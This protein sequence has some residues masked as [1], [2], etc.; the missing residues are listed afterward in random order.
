M[1][2]ISSLAAN[3]SLL[4][5]IFRTRSRLFNLET[6][7][8]SEKISQT[9][10]GIA[11]QSERLINQENTQA[12]LEQYIQ[13]N[14]L[15]DL[16]LKV[17]NKVV[18]NI[19]KVVSEFKTA[20]LD[21]QTSDVKDKTEV[22]DI[23][24][25]AF[26]S[27][28]SIE[29]DLNTSVDGRF[30]FAGARIGTQPVNFGLTNLADYQNIF[31][32]SRIQ[33]PTTRDAHLEDFT[34]NKD[35]GTSAANWLQF[36]RNVGAVAQVDTITVGGTVEVGDKFSV[37]LNGVVF[38]FVAATTSANDVAVGLANAIN[39]GTEPVTAS[40]PAGGVFTLTADTAGTAFTNTVATTETDDTAADAQTIAT[41]S[42]TPNTSGGSIVTGTSSEFTNVTVGSTITITGTGGVNDGTYEVTGKTGTT[43]NIRTEQ[44]TDEAANPVT[45]SYQDPADSTK[46]ITVN[47]TMAFTR[48]NN[49]MVRSAGDVITAIPVGAK[50]TITNSATNNETFTVKSND[51][52]NLVVESK[53]FTD[54]GT[55]GAPYFTYT[56][57][58]A[59]NNLNFVDG[60]ASADTIIGPA[61]TFQDAAGNALPVGSK[62]TVTG[63]ANNG[64]TFTIASVSSDASTVTL[65]STDA[66][67]AAN[68]ETSVLRIEKAAGTISSTS[69]F[70]G[71]EVSMTHRVDETR[72]FE[73]D[74]N[75][76]DPGFEKAIR[77]M[78]II[79][80]GIFQ[81][82]GGLDQNTGRIDNA[83]YL[84]NSALVR[85]PGGTPPF[86]TELTS[87]IEQIELDVGFDRSLI[88][89]TNELHF[90]II[91]FMQTSI[92]NTE[93]INRT[94]VTTLLL[95]QQ[96]ALEASFQAF[97]RIRQLNLGN[98]LPIG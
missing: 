20:L 22:K 65:V 67:T 69:F 72:K 84:L 59:V 71:D 45:I 94:E 32:G 51:G 16:R 42:T 10:G 91:N 26:S 35:S 78:K 36:E 57:A 85:S 34:F 11:A 8:A 7:L 96:L 76:I 43:L 31:D 74:L 68:S 66:V 25:K 3:T 87:N 9:Y 49:T 70:N 89:T 98:Y 82:E 97:A 6:Q 81:T 88:H 61:S 48:S 2:R 73:Y 41:A 23:Q 33:A 24:D 93:G 92:K 75:A 80:Q 77:A 39:A 55:A 62:F 47:S 5:Q 50:I 58:G 52:T 60:G 30:L 1:T 4:Q 18:G 29:T 21:Y 54:Q 13:N 56:G 63:G 38:P 17:T 83:I 53:R 12:Q 95:D 40:A 27:L 46:T 28:A 90:D 44:L 79:A 37:T 64:A 19:H 14:E 86:G 15:M